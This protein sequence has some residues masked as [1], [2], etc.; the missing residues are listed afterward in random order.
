MIPACAN[1]LASAT[2]KKR[3]IAMRRSGLIAALYSRRAWASGA[4]G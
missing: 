1:A 4:L 3:K 2:V